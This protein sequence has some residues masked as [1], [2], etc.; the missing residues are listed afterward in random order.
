MNPL[1]P[2][3][4]YLSTPPD[5][6]DVTQVYFQAEFNRFEVKVFILLDW[7]PNQS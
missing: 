3:A 5:G 6:Q 2:L 7:F 1:N 4:M